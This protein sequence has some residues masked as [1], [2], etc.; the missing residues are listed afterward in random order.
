MSHIEAG[1]PIPTTKEGMHILQQL[2]KTFTENVSPVIDEPDTYPDAI[3]RN[4]KAHTEK[5]E[6]ASGDERKVL[7]DTWENFFAQ[8]NHLSS[9]HFPIFTQ[10][11]I[12]LSGGRVEG[13]NS[14][15]RIVAAPTS[16]HDIEEINLQWSP[17]RSKA[18]AVPGGNAWIEVISDSVAGRIEYGEDARG[19]RIARKPR[20]THERIL[21]DKYKDPITGDYIDSSAQRVEIPIATPFNLKTEGTLFAQNVFSIVKRAQVRG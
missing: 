1:R 3:A 7:I 16:E 2:G 4:N 19:E 15:A 8:G 13:P 12:R 18:T 21:P 6:P 11:M 14:E 9:V 17:S 10:N 20:R 5:L